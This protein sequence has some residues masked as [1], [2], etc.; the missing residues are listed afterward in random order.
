MKIRNYLRLCSLFSMLVIFAGNHTSGQN[1]SN[2]SSNKPVFLGAYYYN[3]WTDPGNSSDTKNSFNAITEEL[4]SDYPERKP[5]WG[6]I[7]SS[8]SIMKAQIDAAANAGIDFFSFDWYFK[9][10]T[11]NMPLNQA[12]D[13][14][15]KAPNKARLKFCLMVAN[16]E[17]FLTGPENWPALTS[18]WIKLFKN[19]SY[20]KVAGKPFLI[21]FSVSSLIKEFGSATAV[22]VA[23]DSLRLVAKKEGTKGVTIG[24]CVYGNSKSV[25]EAVTCGFD[26]LTGYNYHG[27]GLKANQVETP[28]ANMLNADLQ[29]WNQIKNLSSLPYIPVATLNWDPRPWRKNPSTIPHFVGY[30][31]NSVYNSITALQ[32]WISGNQDRTSKERMAL[33]YAWNENGEGGWLTPSEMLKDSLLQGIKKAVLIKNK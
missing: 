16:H 25:E 5:I 1:I 2:N 4:K 28:I 18:E 8:P 24:A 21:F 6:W 11:A 15:L 19:S 13:L 9:D 20:L 17:P 26:I 30:S 32:Q 29:V 33:L 12:L 3:G 7:T 22:H 10:G 23:L 31:L 27:A 14:Y